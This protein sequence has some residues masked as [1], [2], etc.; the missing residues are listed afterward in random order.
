MIRITFYFVLIVLSIRI[1]DVA[2]SQP[3]YLNFFAR[4]Y[5]IM[6]PCSCGLI[7]VNSCIIFF[8]ILKLFLQKF[9][10]NGK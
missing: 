6:C 3:F 9:C 5:N 4:I 8:E 7:Y 1:S 10:C 2:L